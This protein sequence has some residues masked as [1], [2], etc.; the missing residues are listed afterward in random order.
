MAP[1]GIIHIRVWSNMMEQVSKLE[2][3]KSQPTQSF[4]QFLE[5]M[6]ISWTATAII[7]QYTHTAA[8]LVGVSWIE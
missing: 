5:C 2:L 3:L 4:N 1:W 8:L 6:T 7:L